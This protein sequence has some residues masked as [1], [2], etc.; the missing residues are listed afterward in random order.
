MGSAFAAASRRRAEIMHRQASQRRRILLD[1]LL[2]TYTSRAGTSN[3]R[4]QVG[5]RVD[6]KGQDG[7]DQRADGDESNRVPNP[8]AAFKDEIYH[9]SVM[10]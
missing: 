2:Q 7:S 5:D 4:L 1:A 10:M 8:L 6:E 9:P 3:G